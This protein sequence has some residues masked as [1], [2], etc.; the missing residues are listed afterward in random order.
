MHL[1]S[2]S[3]EYALVGSSSSLPSHVFA[4]SASATVRHI[5]PLDIQFLHTRSSGSFAAS[6]LGRKMAVAFRSC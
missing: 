1:L 2:Q 6:S 4:W 5:Q 3:L